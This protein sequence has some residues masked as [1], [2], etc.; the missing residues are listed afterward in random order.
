MEN[1]LIKTLYIDDEKAAL[2]NFEQLFHDDFEV[3]TAISVHRE[4]RLFNNR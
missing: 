3:Y 2:F 1:E 4:W